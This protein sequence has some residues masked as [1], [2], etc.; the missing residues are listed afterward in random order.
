MADEQ[1]KRMYQD[2]DEEDSSSSKSLDMDLE[3][4]K[5]LLTDTSQ[6]FLS[7]LAADSSSEPTTSNSE[8][9]DRP[10]ANPIEGGDSQTARLDTVEEVS[11]PASSEYWQLD[12]MDAA[13][14]D[15]SGQLSEDM[16]LQDSLPPD[17]AVPKSSMSGTSK[18]EVYSVSEIEVPVTT[19]DGF[20]DLR[21]LDTKSPEVVTSS[22]AR[23]ESYKVTTTTVETQS[24]STKS[25]YHS[26]LSGNKRLFP[27]P[28]WFMN[29]FILDVQPSVEEPN[30]V[31]EHNDK[32]SEE[33][34]LSISLP[35]DGEQNKSNQALKDRILKILST[36]DEDEEQTS[37]QHRYFRSDIYNNVSIF[38][39]NRS[40]HENLNNSIV[41][42]YWSE[43]SF[44][45]FDFSADI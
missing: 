35:S 31:I 21:V 20:D 12:S 22:N 14:L 32:S 24:T 26:L 16:A 2:A 42:R 8:D 13:R 34:S 44:I 38:C 25:S 36:D 11:E 10:A 23:I 37:Q 1:T 30:T 40:E 28:T 5:P 45:D 6:H 15:S 27:C 43:M 7:G 9:F 17:A 41:S 29:C 18:E 33:E 4:V 19:F 39:R 3:T